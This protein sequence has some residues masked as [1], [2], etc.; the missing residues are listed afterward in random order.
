MDNVL[1]LTEAGEGIGFG[2]LTRCS[3]IQRF[4]LDNSIDSTILLH[5]KGK[6]F[7]KCDAN[8][9]IVNWLNKITRL[10]THASKYNIVIVDSYIADNKFYYF[11]KT[12]F[13]KVI[14]IDDYNRIVYPVDLILNPNIFGDKLDYSNQFANVIGGREFI[15]LRNA[16]LEK[17]QK[18]IV[19]RDI[20]KL[21][22]TLGGSDYRNLLPDIINS[23]RVSN[24]KIDVI[25]G[26]EDYKKRLQN[27]LLKDNIT[28][29]G[30][31]EGCN[32]AS[33]LFDADIVISGAGQ[34]LNELAYLG[35]PAISI[36]VDD[37]QKF[38]I[39]AFYENGFLLDTLFWNDKNLINKLSEILAIMN[40]QKLRLK[41]SNI[42]R[43]LVN[44]NGIENIYNSICRFVNES[45]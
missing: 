39:Q 13:K 43:G 18:F 22:I 23:L 26:T 11:L 37:D 1:F 14:A 9:Q 17:D 21:L 41:L 5:L 34:T 30:Y 28:C 16:I 45:N 7:F 15:I 31:I 35:V 3:A 2:H 27:L 38:N 32:M 42:G 8:V 4:F 44:R 40:D 25:A 24:L 19:K 10:K 6:E 20:Q 12:I 33:F 29:F 36:C